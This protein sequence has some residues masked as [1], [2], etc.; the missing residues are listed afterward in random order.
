MLGSSQGTSGD[1]LSLDETDLEVYQAYVQY[2][3]PIAEGV[4]VKFGKFG[5]TIGTEVAPTIYNWNITRG[6]VYNLF[7]PITHV[8]I[9]ANMP[10]AE[11]FD[12]SLG[13]VNENYL[14]A[15]P[16]EVVGP[17]NISGITANWSSMV[18][19]RTGATCP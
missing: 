16:Q 18:I 14:P 12:V 4:T 13:Y 9:I 8:G 17:T 6:N 10:F 19:E 3:A 2:L 11:Y 15:S 1:G 7:E 5:T